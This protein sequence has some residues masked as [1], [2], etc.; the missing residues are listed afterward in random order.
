MTTVDV[1]SSVTLLGMLYS[2]HDGVLN[3]VCK[4][5]YR[6]AQS[7]L[8]L[9]LESSLA[10]VLQYIN[11][12]VLYS[13][14]SPSIIAPHTPPAWTAQ[15]GITYLPTSA[16][17]LPFSQTKCCSPLPSLL[18]SSYSSALYSPKY[19]PPQLPP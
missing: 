8:R 4:F 3:D 13:S 14:I 6:W 19:P 9:L 11:Q 16:L 15:F 1:V 5:H 18:P 12:Q 2:L 17:Y 7:D 10:H